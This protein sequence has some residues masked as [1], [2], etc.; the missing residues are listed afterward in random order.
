MRQT[1]RE[2]VCLQPK[3]GCVEIHCCA[4]LGL[5][6]LSAFTQFT[7]ETELHLQESCQT[8]LSCDYGSEFCNQLTK[9]RIKRAETSSKPKIPNKKQDRN[10]Q[11]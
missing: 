11:H 5:Q 9:E 6:S 3:G 7:K 10:T 1:R 2:R 8:S 4:S